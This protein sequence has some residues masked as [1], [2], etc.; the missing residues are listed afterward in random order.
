MFTPW[1]VHI[2]NNDFSVFI[3]VNEIKKDFCILLIESE[4]LNTWYEQQILNWIRISNYLN[5]NKNFKFI[6]L[7]IY[8]YNKFSISMLIGTISL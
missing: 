2:D 4:W 3:V 7:Y 6:L 1:H 5:Q 8:I